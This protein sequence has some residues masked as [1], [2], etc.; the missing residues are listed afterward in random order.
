MRRRDKKHGDG[1][2]D[3]AETPADPASPTF[4]IA[5][6]TFYR[7]AR[8]GSL[9]AR[10]LERALKPRGMDQPHWRVLM[11]LQEHEPASMG[12]IAELAVMKLP[13]VVKLV[14][15]MVEEGYVRTA[16]RLSD[17]RVMEVGITPLGRREL[18][19]VKRAAAEVYRAAIEGLEAAEVARL[20]ALLGHL[21]RNLLGAPAPVSTPAAKAATAQVR[22]SRRRG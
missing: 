2:R 4:R 5:D 1:H 11:I 15:R 14:Q 9:Y 12:L 16:P 10:R 6:Y 22:A 7:M 19:H 21:E 8:A 13:T 3:G 18:V 17:Q 20:N